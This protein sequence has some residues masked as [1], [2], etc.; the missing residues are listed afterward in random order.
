MHTTPPASCRQDA[1]RPRARSPR[2]DWLR[3][4]SLP[5]NGLSPEREIELGRRIQAG[6]LQ[7][8]NEFLEG[9]LESARRI[10]AGVVAARNEL[11][12]GNLALVAWIV[13]FRYR[14]LNC[15]VLDQ[16]D[17]DQAGRVGL[18]RAAELWDPERGYRFC[19]Y[20]GRAI[21]SHLSRALKAHAYFV[22]IPSYRWRKGQPTQYVTRVGE[23]AH[24]PPARRDAEVH[25]LD[26]PRRQLDQLLARLP[27][28]DQA[29]VWQYVRDPDGRMGSTGFRRHGIARA[30]RLIAELRERAE[31][32]REGADGDE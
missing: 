1:P 12:E 18:M 3:G 28:R 9:N 11:A 14:F 7:A 19:T 6:R 24:D 31:Q 25:E 4:S 16:D 22:R 26:E 21:R 15:N 30:Q 20:A 5:G 8:H 23:L 17:L 32:E 13:S 29:L 10:Q 2:R 27:A